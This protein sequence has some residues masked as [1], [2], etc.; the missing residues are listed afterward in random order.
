M[1]VYYII[2]IL[3]RIVLLLLLIVI[4]PHFTCS[5]LAPKSGHLRINPRA[6]REPTHLTQNFN[7]HNNQCADTEWGDLFVELGVLIILKIV[8]RSIFRRDC[9]SV[10]RL[11]SAM[12]H[13]IAQDGRKDFPEWLKVKGRTQFIIILISEWFP[14][15]FFSVHRM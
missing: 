10:R 6:R 15:L 12:K 4:G 1:S 5:A 2:I 7:R 14:M 3:D 9:H 13:T 11:F 8:I